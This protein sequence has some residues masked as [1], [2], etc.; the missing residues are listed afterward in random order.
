MSDI[1]DFKMYH[2]PENEAAITVY[3]DP[4]EE[5]VIVGVEAFPQRPSNSRGIN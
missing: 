3:S 5:L 1:G 4:E 2:D